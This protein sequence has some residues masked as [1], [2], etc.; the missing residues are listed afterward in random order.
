M[1]KIAV[2][3]LLSVF[4][5]PLAARSLTLEGGYT[6]TTLSDQCLDAS[7]SYA[8]DNLSLGWRVYHPQNQIAVSWHD[9]L[10]RWC[11]WLV[12]GDFV[13]DRYGVRMDSEGAI[14]PAFHAAG[15]Y[16]ELLLGMQQT[17]RLHSDMDHPL[18]NPDQLA[19]HLSLG[20]E[21]RSWQV[22]LG[23]HSS[24]F[25]LYSYQWFTPVV[26]CDVDYRFPDGWSCGLHG[27]VRINDAAFNELHRATLLS[28]TA[29]VTRSL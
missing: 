25:Y 6:E 22:E 8:G 5:S 23:W 17:L 18:V 3:L 2:I 11:A 15:F 13:A 14:G 4:L 10:G 12:K 16:G 26:T 1:R 20:W 21:N 27:K 9:S 29:S 24:T 7:L 19:A 28:L